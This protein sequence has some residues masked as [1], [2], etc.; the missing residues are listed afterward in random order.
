MRLLAVVNTQPVGASIP[1]LM[2]LHLQK[3][4][5]SEAPDIALSVSEAPRVCALAFE[6]VTILFTIHRHLNPASSAL[7]PTFLLL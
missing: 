6:R 3:V 7:L 1:L 4:S 5:S 2:L